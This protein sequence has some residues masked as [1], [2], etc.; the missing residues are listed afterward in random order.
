M[1]HITNT[2]IKTKDIRFLGKK[3]RLSF[4]PYEARHRYSETDALKV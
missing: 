1:T 2:H 4:I 3:F